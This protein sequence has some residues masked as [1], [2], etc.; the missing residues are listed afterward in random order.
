MEA[1]PE[2]L[3]TDDK[4]LEKLRE[5]LFENLKS[6]TLCP[7]KCKIDRISGKIGICK[8]PPNVV[9]ASYSVH[10]GEE[11]P[12]S[13]VKGSG[14]IFFSYCTLK[15]IYCQNYPISQLHN[16][17]SISEE[18]LAQRML[19]LQGKGC[20]NINLV[21]PTHFLP[22][23]LK[24][25]I[26]AKKRGLHIP[27]VYNTS[28]WE[29]VEIVKILKFFVDVYLPDAR[30]S[31]DKIAFEFSKATNYREIN[32]NALVEMQKNQP[33]NLFTKDGFIIKGLIIRILILPNYSHDAI[34]TLSR[35]HKKLGN[36]V[37]I[38]LMSQ[39]Y[40]CFKSLGHEKL[41]RK[42]SKEE[43]LMVKNF[44]KESGF[45]MGWIQDDE[46]L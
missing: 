46:W 27:I 26:I 16:G 7:H 12:I 25:L 5:E 18:E 37:Y 34:E 39:Y 3:L 32:T 2:Y 29:N 22:S 36:K 21:T 17:I 35:I 1:L 4:I 31:D 8:A 15:C 24:A 9:V 41:G 44:V 43:Y 42:I 14:T 38:S 40:P 13:G 30:Y 45:E 28:G 23:I 33:I 19:Y 6:C 11:P 10:M 20:H